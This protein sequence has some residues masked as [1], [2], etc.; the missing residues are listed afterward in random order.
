MEQ[1]FTPRVDAAWQSLSAWHDRRPGIGIVLGSGLGAFAARA[2]G[3]AVPF[4]SLTGM[5]RPTVQGHAGTF[6]I[7]RSIVVMAGRFHY[8]EGHRI[9]DV[10]LPVFLMHR[11][12]VRTLIVT[13][14]SGAVNRKLAVGNLVLLRDHINLMGVNP[15]RGP[16]PGPGPRFPDMT[17][18]Y[19]PE[20]RSLA[21][22][23]AGGGLPEGVYAA[24]SGP[25]YET[26]AEIR[27][28]EA[29]G[30]DLVGMST[31]PEVIAARYLGIRVM[32]VSCVT[33][34]A[35][36]VLPQPLDHEEVIQ[37]GKEAAPRFA[38]LLEGVVSR[39]GGTLGEG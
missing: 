35:A 4:A 8:Y 1:D 32:G 6:H 37:A 23:A 9:D 34:M 7:G 22:S 29:I 30:A 12:G 26:P 25:T 13:N 20:L 15:L 36:G 10:V 18:T 39:L 33:N 3:A 21:Q 31:V 17:A 38:E 19:D 5:P 28:L 11:M 27:M 14:A 16:N 24:F 2:G